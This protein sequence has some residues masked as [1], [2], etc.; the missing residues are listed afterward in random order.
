MENHDNRVSKKTSY[1]NPKAASFL[2]ISPA[3]WNKD[4]NKIKNQRKH[5]QNSQIAFAKIMHI[6]FQT[7][8]SI[9]ILDFALLHC[10]EQLVI[11]L[12]YLTYVWTGPSKHYSKDFYP[13]AI[14]ANAFQEKQ[15]FYNKIWKSSFINISKYI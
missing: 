1:N 12:H 4:M 15:C 14:Q 10:C 8:T 6:N 3:R 7:K 11:V 2:H 5:E 13:I 9:K